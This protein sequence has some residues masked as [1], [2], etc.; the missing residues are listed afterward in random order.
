MK[1]QILYGQLNNNERHTFRLHLLY[2]VIEGMMNGAIVLN[3]YIFI[4][5]LNG[6]NYQLSILFQTSVIVLLFS[7]LFNELIRRTENK[8]RMLI[9]VALMTHIPLL[10]MLFFPGAASMPSGNTYMHY[11]FLFIFFAYFLSRPLVYPTINLFLKSNY[12]DDYFGRLYSLGTSVQKITM[13]LTAFGFGILLD[14]NPYFYRY[15]YPLLGILGVVSIIWLSKIRLPEIPAQQF[16]RGI[17]EAIR[18]SFGRMVKILKTNHPYRD[19]EVGFVLYG[20]AFMS[21]KAV[22]TLFYDVE[23]QLNY[24]SVAFYQNIFNILAI[25][26][27][28]VFG[29]LIGKVD[30]RRFVNI[31]YAALAL[32][33]AAIAITQYLPAYFMLWQLKVYYSLILAIIFQGV[34]VATM[35]L[36]WYIGSAYFCSKEEAG[37]YQSVHLTLTGARGI[38]APIIGIFFYEQIGFTGTFAVGILALLGAIWLMGWSV[39]KRGES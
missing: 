32:M 29:R 13:L 11:I 39:R 24:T 37:D 38:F 15:V 28:P 8:K 31:N 17:K 34:F 23:L 30:P 22:I 18:D 35:S 10:L 20:F 14:Y 2:S 16:K 25:F 6:S 19:Y 36:A 7:V 21:T 33:L 26:L 9:R 4:K 1:I 12:R 3:E 5:A 27:L